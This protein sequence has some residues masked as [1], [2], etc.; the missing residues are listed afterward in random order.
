MIGT[1]P[2]WSYNSILEEIVRGRLLKDSN[3]GTKFFSLSLKRKWQKLGCLT[4]SGE[5]LIENLRLAFRSDLL[6]IYMFGSAIGNKPL[7]F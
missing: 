7:D 2:Q 3:A 6:D 4:D 5:L 1:V